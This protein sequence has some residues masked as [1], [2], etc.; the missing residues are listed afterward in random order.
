MTMA[1]TAQQRI[2]QTQ[3]HVRA[4][5]QHLDKFIQ[6]VDQQQSTLRRLQAVWQRGQS[7]RVKQKALQDATTYSIALRAVGQQIDQLLP[8]LESSLTALMSD[9]AAQ[10]KEHQQLSALAKSAEV[11]NSTLDLTEVLNQVMDMIISLTGAERSFLMLL[12]EETGEME[13]KVARN[14]DR[15]TIGGSSFE[16]SRTI[17]NTVAREGEPVVTTNAQADPR[18]RA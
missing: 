12:D 3:A 10:V 6:V 18:F 4:L 1:D 15:E 13:F 5:R 16:I 7:A 2:E 14:L 9:L 11:I 8:Q 17:V